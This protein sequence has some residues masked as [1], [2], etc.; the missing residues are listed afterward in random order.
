MRRGPAPYG[1][2]TARV[3]LL[4]AGALL[5]A[6]RDSAAAQSRTTPAPA[7]NPLVS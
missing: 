6:P 3:A 2:W 4:L 5:L 1:T 7:T